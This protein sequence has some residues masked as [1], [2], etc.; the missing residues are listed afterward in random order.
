LRGF[1][2]KPQKKLDLVLADLDA[3]G[4]TR[5]PDLLK[6]NFAKQAEEGIYLEAHGPGR[7]RK[8]ELP[9]GHPAKIHYRYLSAGDLTL[10]FDPKSGVYGKG[11][12]TS[13]IPLLNRLKV[14]IELKDGT[15]SLVGDLPLNGSSPF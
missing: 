13:S 7:T 4:K 8:L 15:L 14:P 12:I 1:I 3:R 9:A 5:I 10:G 6:I 2:T 11:S